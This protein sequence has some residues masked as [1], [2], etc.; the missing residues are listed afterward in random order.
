MTRATRRAR[1]LGEIVGVSGRDGASLPKSSIFGMRSAQLG[2]AYVAQGEGRTRHERTLH[3]HSS[4]DLQ[5]L[6]WKM[7]GSAV[8]VS[9]FWAVM[10]VPINAYFI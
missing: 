6:I 2:L 9:A 8:G 1:K 4:S 5:G 7:L 3:I 10:L